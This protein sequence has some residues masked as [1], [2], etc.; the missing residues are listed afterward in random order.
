MDLHFD[1]TLADDYK[2][3]RQK[4]RVMSE[5]WFYKNMFCPVCGNLRVEKFE[6]NRPVADFGCKKCGEIFE[7]KTKCGRLG[8]KIADGAYHTMMERLVDLKNPNLFVMQYDKNFCVTDLMLIPKFFFVPSV[9]EKRKPLSQNAR[10]AGWIGCNILVS[11]IPVQGRIPV[12]QKKSIFDSSRVVEN[13][14][15][16][17][18]L[19][20]EN[21]ENRGWL[22]DVLNCIN[23]I[24]R[25]DFF[26]SDVYDFAR[27]L[28]EK[29]P[30]NKN[31]H[32][33][34]RQQLQILRDK[35]FVEFLERGHYR[36]LHQE[37]LCS[38]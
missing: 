11:E 23:S 12:V 18:I 38:P 31:V 3:A 10:R 15:R 2:S 19:R 20:T 27:T 34:I 29:H 6:N 26:T 4:I 21:I 37:F 32:A 5:N 36:K 24:P 13:F 30:A 22:F 25:K 17:K 33:K 35:G 8:K 16:I 1:E 9:I 28:S 14:N 7:L